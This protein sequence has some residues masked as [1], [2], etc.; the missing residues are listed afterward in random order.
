MRLYPVIR[1]GEHTRLH[2]RYIQRSK[3]AL[4]TMNHFVWLQFLCIALTLLEQGLSFQPLL[5]R[6][7]QRKPL[8]SSATRTPRTRGCLHALVPLSADDVEELISSGKP[9][10]DQYATYV[11]RT[12]QEKYNTFFEWTAVAILGVFFSYFLSFVLGGFVATIFGSLFF[13]WGV[14]SPEFKAYQ[15]NWEF[16]GGQEVVDFDVD[17]RRTEQRPRLFGALFL[18]H[19][20]DICV[21]GDDSSVEYDFRDFADYSMEEDELQQYTGHPYLLRVQCTDLN[22][23]ALQIHCRL[24]EDYVHLVPGMPVCTLLLSNDVEFNELAA[25][26]DLYVVDHC[27]IGDY[28]YLNRPA[29][30]ALLDEDDSIWNNLM[31]EGKVPVKSS[32][33][34]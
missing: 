6:A 14:L 16:L 29:L 33:R 15:R 4:W 22:D 20:A 3:P 19:I 13:F 25:L 21:V 30:E 1:Y 7:V 31:K 8:L 32:I 12:M 5:T 23:R 2:V 24:S 10:G 28:P 26:T 9:T 11:G 27:W 18:G 34:R 17:T